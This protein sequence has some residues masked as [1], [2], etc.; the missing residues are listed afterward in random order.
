[1][2]ERISVI[3][4]AL[5][6]S[7]VTYLLLS[8]WSGT[9]PGKSESRPADIHYEQIQSSGTIKAAY[10]VGAPLF[11][12]DPNTRA[13]SGIFYDILNAAAG[14]LS[15]KAEWTEQVGYGEMIQGLN[16]HRYDAVGSGV[17]INGAR[18]RNADFT[19]PVY[20]D[21][22]F[23][24][25]R[26]DDTRFDTSLTALDSP[27]YTISTMDGELGA[28]IAKTDFPK[29]KTLELPQSAD[30]SQLIENVLNHKADVVFL[31]LAPAR[32]YQST[33]PEKIR[34]VDKAKP[35]RVFPVAIMLPKGDSQLR[36]SLDYAL[37][38]MLTDGEIDAILEKYEIVNGSVLRV[39]PPYQLVAPN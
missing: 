10:A 7:V 8:L 13:K 34:A 4:T 26:V 36:T 30:F 23:P 18:G 31:A 29:A 22:V 19:I 16:A 1:M 33:N 38:E 12:I 11:M 3:V 27:A 5:I 28:A 14:K 25:V 6:A 32:Q 35:I 39:A 20:Y 9:L 24:Y 17:W 21:A 15:L 2:S 37:T